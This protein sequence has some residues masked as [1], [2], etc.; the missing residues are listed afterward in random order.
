MQSAGHPEL[1]EIILQ[2][3]ESMHRQMDCHLAQARA[4]SGPSSGKRCS[5][6]DCA[7]GLARTLRTLYAD[8]GLTI[9]V[10]VSREHLIGGLREDLDEMLGNL[11]DN[12]CKWARSCVLIVS[13]QSGA[14]ILVDID[15]DGPGIPQGMRDAVLQ[16]GVRSDERTG[17]S[18]LGLA[19]VRDLAELYGGSVVLDTSPLGGLRARLKLPERL[20]AIQD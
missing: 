2:Q 19:I 12:A 4:A 1:S 17:G 14:D 8:R 10:Q 18:G 5:V 3:V 20:P 15:D 9:E 11:L 7:Q 6:Y 16:R 13:Q